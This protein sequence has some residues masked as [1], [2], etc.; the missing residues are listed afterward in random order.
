[1]SL[2]YECTTVYTSLDLIGNATKYLLNM[3]TA[4]KIYKLPSVERGKGPYVNFS[5]FKMCGWCRIWSNTSCCKHLRTLTHLTILAW[6]NKETF[7]EISYGFSFCPACPL[8]HLVLPAG[9]HDTCTECSETYSV[10]PQN[11]ICDAFLTV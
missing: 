3:S 4:V 11:G 1:M 6:L 5:Y 8:F 7:S 2:K 9:S 10:V